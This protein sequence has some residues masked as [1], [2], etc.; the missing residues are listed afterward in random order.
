MIWWMT[1]IL[2]QTAA[3]ESTTMGDI[4]ESQVVEEKGV[5]RTQTNEEKKKLSLAAVVQATKVADMRLKV[6]PGTERKPLRRWLSVSVS[7]E[8]GGRTAG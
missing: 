5:A 7:H 4:T 3:S 6:S 2:H 1:K 8:T